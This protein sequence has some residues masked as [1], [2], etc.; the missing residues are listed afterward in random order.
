MIYAETRNLASHL[1]ACEAI[2]GETS[3]STESA[4]LRAYEK[5]RHCLC[6]LAGVAAFQSLAFRALTVAKL[7]APALWT[8]EVA[9]DG[10]LEGLDEFEAQ[11]GTGM[12]RASDAGVILIAQL[13]G[14]LLIFLGETLTLTLVRNVWPDAAWDECNSESRRT[15]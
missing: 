15:A 6:V 13:L 12:D 1:L 2:P 14:Q 5:L 7:E 8:V 11:P 9:A 4:T 10:S 3:K